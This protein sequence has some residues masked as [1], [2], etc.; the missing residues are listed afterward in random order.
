MKL[1]H[2]G[3]SFNVIL[4]FFILTILLLQVYSIAMREPF[5]NVQQ[6]PTSLDPSTMP[7][8]QPGPNI[9]NLPQQR[10]I[11]NTKWTCEK[12]Q[13]YGEHEV[14]DAYVIARKNTSGLADCAKLDNTPTE[15]TGKC[16]VYVDKDACQMS[17]ATADVLYPSRCTAEES[18]DGD[19]HS[20]CTQLKKQIWQCRAI[21][22]DDGIIYYALRKNKLNDIECLGNNFDSC[23]PFENVLTCVSNIK[24]VQNNKYLQCGEMMANL[25]GTSG[26]TTP[27]HYCAVYKDIVP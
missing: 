27:T 21:P 10:P 7:T 6:V 5:Y 4:L 12:I 17:L 26:Y 19:D 18:R 16:S 11:V 23:I 24:D 15:H 2:I 1:G 25:Y 3:S 14:K 20:T 8:T 13:H 22:K 9:Q